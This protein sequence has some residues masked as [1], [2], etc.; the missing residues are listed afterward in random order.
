MPYALKFNQSNFCSVLEQNVKCTFF[1]VPRGDCMTV[2]IGHLKMETDELVENALSVFSAVQEFF[3]PKSEDSIA[4]DLTVIRATVSATN[5]LAPLSI[6]LNKTALLDG[7]ARA[8]QSVEDK[9][10]NKKALKEENAKK[11]SC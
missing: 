11:L 4:R 9:L 3:S 7:V 2:K 5:V 1:R 6:W 10:L 8:Q